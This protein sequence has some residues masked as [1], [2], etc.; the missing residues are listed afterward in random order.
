MII[1]ESKSFKIIVY[2]KKMINKN[3][4]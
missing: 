4:N 1:K 3:L 2:K